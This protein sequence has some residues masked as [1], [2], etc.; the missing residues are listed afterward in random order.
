M[1]VLSDAFLGGSAPRLQ[2][3]YLDAIA[4]PALPTL[5]SSTSDLVELILWQIPEAGY[6]SP[7]AM[8]VSLA[9]LTKLDSLEIGFHWRYPRSRPSPG[10]LHPLTRIVLPALTRFIFLGVSE[11]LE[12]CLAQ[13]DTPRLNKLRITYFKQLGFHVPQLSRFLRR[14][15]H[16][17][18]TRFDNAHL[19]F[20]RGDIRIGFTS[21]RQPSSPHFSSKGPSLDLSIFERRAR[22]SNFAL[23]PGAHTMFCYSPR[24]R[25]SLHRPSVLKTGSAR[26]RR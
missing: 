11:Y 21:S 25:P 15:E 8:V 9:A 23:D 24:R 13:I 7:D 12:D 22:P 10:H 16:L 2:S 18:P 26:R 1:L 3:I 4:F 14:Q 20:S 6:I 5:L 17:Q 19:E